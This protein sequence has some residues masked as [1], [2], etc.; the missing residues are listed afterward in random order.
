MNSLSAMNGSRRQT[1]SWEE[2]GRSPLKLH[3]QAREGLKPGGQ[4]ASPADCNGN[5]LCFFHA[6]P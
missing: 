3:L 1:G 5:L 2:G 6:C 4:A